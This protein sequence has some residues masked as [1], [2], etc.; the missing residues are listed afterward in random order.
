MLDEINI[1]ILFFTSTQGNKL[2]DISVAKHTLI[3]FQTLDSIQIK[4]SLQQ[5]A[6]ISLMT[7]INARKAEEDSGKVHVTPCL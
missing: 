3:H 1:W 7:L 4:W 6:E 2:T 5:E